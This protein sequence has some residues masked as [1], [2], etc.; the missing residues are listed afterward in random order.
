MTRPLN[1]LR[2]LLVAAGFCTALLMPMAALAF[3]DAGSTP[4]D[5]TATDAGVTD[6]AS[7]DVPLPTDTTAATPAFN[8]NPCWDEKC[9]AETNACIKDADCKALHDCGT[10]AACQ[11]KVVTSQAISDKI[12][13]LTDAIAKCGWKACADPTKGSCGDDKCGKYLGAKSPCNCD[14]FCESAGDCCQDFKALCFTCEKR[15]D[16]DGQGED[17]PCGCDDTCGDGDAAPCCDDK[18]KICLAATL[19]GTCAN[20][21]CT[22]S[23]PTHG[24]TAAGKAGAACFCDEGCT[25]PTRDDCCADQATACAA[26]VGTDTSSAVDAGSVPIDAASATADAGSTGTGADSASKDAAS[27]VVAGTAAPASSGCTAGST[28]TTPATLVLT[29]LALVGI[30]A[31]RRRLV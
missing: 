27:T 22:K 21:D 2:Q 20:V 16:G 17:W 8:E 6:T 15:C 5:A 10:D 4:D 7:P 3:S 23:T 30:V 24:K 14:A 11:K 31:A 26:P 18:E 1:T 9:A 12:K 13:A 29:L 28:G 25:D 19:E